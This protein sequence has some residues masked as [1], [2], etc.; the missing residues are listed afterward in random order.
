MHF[1]ITI[2]ISHLTYLPLC[3]ILLGANLTHFV[4]LLRHDI[5]GGEV[6]MSAA[7]GTLGR[8]EEYDGPVTGIST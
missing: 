8:I 2:I 6:G 7:A 3:S 5:I 1:C 4:N